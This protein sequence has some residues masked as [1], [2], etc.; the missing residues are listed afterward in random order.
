MLPEVLPA[1]T[2]SAVPKDVLESV[3]DLDGP[4]EICGDE[5][6]NKSILRYCS[7][8]EGMTRFTAT[9]VVL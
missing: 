7:E 1:T 8:F 6:P 3:P 9:C 4:D 5:E 2:V